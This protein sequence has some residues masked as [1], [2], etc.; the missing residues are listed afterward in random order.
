MSNLAVV[1]DPE[2]PGRLAIRPVPDPA[3][4]RGEALVRVHAIS[5]NRGEVRRSGMA[6]AGW[7]PGWDLACVVERAVSL[8]KARWLHVAALQRPGGSHVVLIE[9]I[10]STPATT[11][12]GDARAASQDVVRGG[13]V[14][15]SGRA[16]EIAPHALVELIRALT[17]IAA[18]LGV[19]A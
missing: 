2:A 5:L 13:A 6:P 15:P 17:A 19:R 10:V 16:V 11:L 12:P 4:D 14:A 3:P 1:V 7:R 9:E 18:K 8:G